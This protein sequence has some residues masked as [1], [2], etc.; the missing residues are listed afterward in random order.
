MGP[1]SQGEGGDPN[2]THQPGL[3][4]ANQYISEKQRIKAVDLF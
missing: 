4:G 3:L 2:K 1:G